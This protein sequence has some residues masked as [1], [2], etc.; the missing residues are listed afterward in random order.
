MVHEAIYSPHIDLFVELRVR[1]DSYEMR[2][3][4]FHKKHEIYYLVQGTRRYFIGDTAY[5]INAGDLVIIPSDQI[6]KTSSVEQ[7]G[8]VRYVVNF[9]EDS[10]AP[11]FSP[12]ETLLMDCFSR[13]MPVIRVPMR[14]RRLVE[15]LMQRLLQASSPEEDSPMLQMKRKILLCELL[16]YANEF[17][18]EQEQAE[19][20]YGWVQ[21]E[22]I[23]QV[24]QY[25]ST[26]YQEELTLSNVAA[27]FYISP[28]YLSR[29]FR[30]V[31]NLS[32][33][34]YINGVRVMAAKNLLETTHLRIEELAAQSGFSTSAH[35]TRVF[36]QGTGL[37][38]HQYRKMYQTRNP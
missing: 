23:Q 1:E 15:D 3:F 29:L 27:R 21:N 5:L 33:V 22:L 26:H 20:V 12:S 19:P 28:S 37:S 13:Q 7:S 14:K 9:S 11:Y 6:H 30:R 31:T 18:Y 35:F 24:Q 4:H 16:L 2:S 17:A 34:E 8:H 10:F 32:I 25:I 38:P 36:K